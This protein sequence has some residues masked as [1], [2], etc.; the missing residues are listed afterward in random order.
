MA[1]R[2]HW[3][4]YRCQA[5]GARGSWIFIATFVVPIGLGHPC[6][7]QSSTFAGCV[8]RTKISC[9]E[10]G[11]RFDGRRPEPYPPKSPGALTTLAVT[12]FDGF[13]QSVAGKPE[14][15]SRM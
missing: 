4:V 15:I 10:K 3:S 11:V 6:T 9:V 12:M 2:I 14:K 5:A 8:P 7:Y 1:S 13:C